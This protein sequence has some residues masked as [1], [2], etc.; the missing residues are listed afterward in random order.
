MSNV[1]RILAAVLLAAFSVGPVSAA[2]VSN[3]PAI[4]AQTAGGTVQGTVQDETG[5]P[6][7]GAT[8]F[9]H[10]ANSYTATTDAK[11]A[12]TLSN[13]NQGLYAV[14]VRKAGYD[15]ATESDLAIA[16]GVTQTV[17]VRLHGATLTSLRTIAT[18]R[19][20]G[21]GTFNTSTASVNT[22]DTQVFE[23][24]AQPQVTRVLNQIPG[25]QISLPQS[26]GNGAAPGAI[27]FPNVRGGLSFETASL[28]DGHP[29]AVGLYGDYVTTFLNSLVLGPVEVIKGPGAMAPQV[30]YAIGGTVNFRTKDPTLNV[31]P[32][33]T[34]GIDNHGG[35]FFNIGVSDTINRLGF[36]VDIANINTPGA[37]NNYQATFIPSGGFVNVGGVTKQLTYNDTAV[38]TIPGTSTAVYNNYGLVACCLNLPGNYDSTAEFVKLRYKFSDATTATVS[39]LGSQTYADQNVNTGT[40]NLGV[41]NPSIN[42]G[43][44]TGPLA[45]NSNVTVNNLF[46]VNN[47]EVN[48]EPIFQAEVRSTLGND[49][50]LARFYHAGIQRIKREGGDNP[51]T[52]TTVNLTLNGIDKYAGAFNGVSTPVSFFDYYM[53]PEIDTLNGYSFEYTHPIGENDLTFA[54]DATRSTTTAFSQGVSTNAN[55]TFK[56]MANPSVSVPSGSS[57]NFQTLMLRGSYHVNPKL[58]ATL[59]LYDNLYQSTYA[60]A[61]GASLSAP[62]ACT[63]DPNASLLNGLFTTQNTSHFD[64]RL[65]LEFRPKNN[66]AVRLAAGSS[67]APPYLGLLTQINQGISYRAGQTTASQRIPNPNI[68]PETAFGYDLGADLRLKDGVTYLSGDVFSTTL[69]NQF[70]GSYSYFNGAT[71]SAAQNPGSGCPAAGVPLVFSSSTNLANARYQGIELGLKRV[72]PTGFGYSLSGAVQR[73]YTYNL[74]A[75]FHCTFVVTAAT[76]CNPSTYNA[77]LGIVPDIN[78]TGGVPSGSNGY[79]GTSGLGG[80]SNQNIPYFQGNLALNYTLKNGAYLEF[81]DTL[82]GKNNSLNEPPFGI[83]YATVRYPISDA[84]SLQVSGDNIFNAYS[85]LFP[86]AGNGV[87]IPL[88]NGTLGATSAGVLGPATYRFVITKTF[89]AFGDKNNP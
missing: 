46:P 40:Q 54:Y 32:D 50:V 38:G 14:E 69:F 61:C 13:I 25:V 21:R 26:S 64:G 15:T 35:T 58:T 10:G 34:F 53:N 22:V 72:V 37:L 77:M 30:N 17:S 49:T 84:L 80:V 68:V 62:A 39:Y 45:A 56:S 42:P 76:P 31:T 75:N 71:C 60:Q 85:G 12:F 51:A 36:V 66:L 28:I 33:Y 88:A 59:S 16:S 29:L 89:G 20:V 19:A 1:T 74:P 81:G 78:Y 65:G 8:V 86:L 5:A 18:V 63:Y 73:A 83:A 6:V 3:A 2:T 23:N 9:V 79:A 27:T 4:V 7:S 52:P 67:I 41:F 55:G 47:R 82:Y 57:Q 70:V 48:N 87:A 44:Y 24:Q 43:T 11:G